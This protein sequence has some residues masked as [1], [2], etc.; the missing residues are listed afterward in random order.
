MIIKV[1]GMRDEENI[2]R[3]DESG[4]ADWM[5]FIF[6]EK[7]PRHVYYVP[8][9]LPRH[10][11]RVGVF[12]NAGVEEILSRQKA[13]A[14]DMIQ[15]HGNESCAFCRAVRQ[16]LRHG[17]LIIKMIAV[18]GED[19]LAQALA[20][21]GVADFLL[22]ETKSPDF[23]GSG[24]KFDWH[25]LHAYNG[26]TPFLI[27]GGIGADDFREVANFR[28]PKFAGIDLNSG[29]E[30]A[31]AIKDVNAIRTFVLQLAHRQA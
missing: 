16:T 2:R 1:C 5:G 3:L 18:G 4:C 8:S 7:S 24:R 11:K 9:Y 26:N 13:F 27:T 19:C 25:L 14:L 29:F 30:L 20:Y 21:E 6:H 28:H 31:P 15:L 17:T 23:G 12:V 22:F 10:C